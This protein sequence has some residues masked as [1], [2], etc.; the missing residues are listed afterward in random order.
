MKELNAFYPALL[1]ALEGD[2]GAGGVVPLLT[3]GHGGTLPNPKPIWLDAAPPNSAFPLVTFN[4][5]SDLSWDTSDTQG[6]EALV[7]VHVWSDKAS[8]SEAAGLIARIETLCFDPAWAVSGFTL[9]HCRPAM[10]RIEADGEG[11]HG[12]VTLKVIIG[13]G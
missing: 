12:V 6:G 7:D 4:E 2:T 3:T 10:Q 1:A 5:A 8:R 13:H 11:F 9:V